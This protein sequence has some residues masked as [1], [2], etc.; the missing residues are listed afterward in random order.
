MWSE[1]SLDKKGFVGSCGEETDTV[2]NGC[3]GTHVHEGQAEGKSRADHEQQLY[4]PQKSHVMICARI[5]SRALISRK[6]LEVGGAGAKIPLAMED[7]V[8]AVEA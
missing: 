4:G 7:G 1:R 8:W 2:R 5:L 3:C 6:R